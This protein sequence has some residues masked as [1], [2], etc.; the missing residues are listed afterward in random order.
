MA[1]PLTTCT[2][3]AKSCHPPADSDT[4]VPGA[5]PYR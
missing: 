3:T 5:H 1:N 4:A 2:V